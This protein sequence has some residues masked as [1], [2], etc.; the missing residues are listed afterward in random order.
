MEGGGDCQPF[1]TLVKKKKRMMSTKAPATYF[2][3]YIK[4]SALNCGVL[5]EAA[6]D[7]DPRRSA[8]EYVVI[9]CNIIQS[10][11]SVYCDQISLW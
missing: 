3:V 10:Q 8:V 1:E 5:H 4:D 6:A 11:L 7:I 9:Q 2:K